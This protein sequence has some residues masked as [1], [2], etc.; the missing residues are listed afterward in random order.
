MIKRRRAA[1]IKKKRKDMITVA[2]TGNMI[3]LKD[4]HGYKEK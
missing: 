1:I 2:R 3:T 4:T